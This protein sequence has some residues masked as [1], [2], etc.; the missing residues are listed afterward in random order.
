MGHTVHGVTVHG[1]GHDGATKQT[2]SWVTQEDVIKDSWAGKTLNLQ[3]KV[4]FG[5]MK[6]SVGAREGCRQK[7]AEVNA[8]QRV[9]S[10]PK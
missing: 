5:K 7:T 1:V 2:D 4:E 6:A 10:C 9:N 3:G 8:L